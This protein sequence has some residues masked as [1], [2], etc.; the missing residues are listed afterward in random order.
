MGDEVVEL[1]QGENLEVQPL[2]EGRQEHPEEEANHQ[3]NLEEEGHR[4]N[5]EEEAN[6]HE[7][8]GHQE[9]FEE[10]GNHHENLREEAA[11]QELNLEEEVGHHENPKEYCLT[12]NVKLDPLF[13]VIL[14]LGLCWL[15]LGIWLVHTEK[16][17]SLNQKL[18]AKHKENLQHLQK[19]QTLQNLNL[20]QS[21]SLSDMKQY[22][23]YLRL[24][25]DDLRQNITKEQQKTTELTQQLENVQQKLLEIQ[26]IVETYQNQADLI[27]RID[28]NIEK[29]EI[30]YSWFEKYYRLKSKAAF[31]SNS[32]YEELDRYA[33]Y[34]TCKPEISEIP[35]DHIIKI[36]DSFDERIELR[37][38]AKKIQVDLFINGDLEKMK[39]EQNKT[40][41]NLP[42][43]TCQFVCELLQSWGTQSTWST[44]EPLIRQ[45]NETTFKQTYEVMVENSL[46][47]RI[48]TFGAKMIYNLGRYLV[49]FFLG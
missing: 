45:S 36:K 44:R 15:I 24:N 5:F 17:E 21:E 11:D 33:R 40:N 37:L 23:Y 48:I 8:E 34:L 43:E 13:G 7:E 46:L 1:N 14:L 2:V 19:I 3:V 6:H 12:I 18:I 42:I 27:N 9:N 20:S 49:G 38:K 35:E 22:N 25:L 16:L 4:E 10:E 30:C 32:D 41:S 47:S 31:K 28:G 26:C 29:I 39:A